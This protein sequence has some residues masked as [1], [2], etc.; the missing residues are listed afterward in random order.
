M[1]V[2]RRRVYCRSIRSAERRG[3]DERRRYFEE[4]SSNKYFRTR[5][6]QFPPRYSTSRPGSG[7]LAS[8]DS[9]NRKLPKEFSREGESRSSPTPHCVG[10]RPTITDFSARILRIESRIESAVVARGRPSGNVTGLNLC[11]V[12]GNWGRMPWNGTFR[13]L[14]P[15]SL[16][17]RPLA[18]NG[19]RDRWSRYTHTH[20][21]NRRSLTVQL[22]SHSATESLGRETPTVSL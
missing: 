4:N 11:R 15:F 22:L 20:T 18:R 5:G 19:Y 6:K 3:Q 17:T 8:L 9:R 12:Q 7:A 10:R 14:T 21:Q 1:A 16:L 2:Y 13:F